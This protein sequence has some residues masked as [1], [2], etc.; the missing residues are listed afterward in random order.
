MFEDYSRMIC[1]SLQLVD[2]TDV[3][4]WSAVC[5]RAWYS[6]NIT[7]LHGFHPRIQ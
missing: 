4:G 3:S 7:T 1:H 5:I 2:N 6:R